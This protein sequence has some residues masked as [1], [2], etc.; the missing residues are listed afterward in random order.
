MAQFSPSGVSV[1]VLRFLRDSLVTAVRMVR[2]YFKGSL[3]HA[4][5]RGSCLYFFQN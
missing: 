1:L 2:E 4:I 5:Q 3:P